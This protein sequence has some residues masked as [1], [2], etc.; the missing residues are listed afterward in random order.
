[1]KVYNN[2][3][4]SEA[5]STVLPTDH[6]GQVSPT[7]ADAVF[8]SGD[9]VVV[10][11]YANTSYDMIYAIGYH[12]PSGVQ[13]Y[14]HVYPNIDANACSVFEDQ[15]I[16]VQKDSNWYT[17]GVVRARASDDYILGSVNFAGTTSPDSKSGCVRFNGSYYISAEY[18]GNANVGVQSGQVTVYDSTGYMVH[19]LINPN[20]AGDADY[21]RFGFDTNFY[22]TTQVVGLT[23]KDTDGTGSNH[24]GHLSLF[25][26]TT[27]L[28]QKT[29]DIPKGDR[30]FE[31]SSFNGPL[32]VDGEWIFAGGWQSNAPTTDYTG[33]LIHCYNPI[34][35][36]SFNLVG[37]TSSEEAKTAHSALGISDADF[38]TIDF[39]RSFDVRDGKLV[40]KTAS[41]AGVIA[42]GGVNGDN[43]SVLYTFTA[44]VAPRNLLSIDETHIATR[45]YAL[46]VSRNAKEDAQTYADQAVVTAVANVVDAAPASLDTLNELAAALGDDENFAVTVTTNLAGKA[47]IASVSTS[48]QEAIDAAALDAT[49]KANAAQAAAIL[50]ASSDA[51]GKAEAARIAAAADATSKANAAQSIAISTASDDATTKANDVQ[52]ICLA[53]ATSKAEAA[54]IAAE[55][56]AAADATAKAAAAQA[57]AA[58]D[59]ATKADAAQAAAIAAA[60][61]DATSKANAALAAAEADATSKAN[62]A[63]AAAEADATAKAEAARI[64]AESAAALDAATKADAAQA[65]AALDATSKADAAQAAA[66]LDA[67]SK[68][69][70]ARIN[71]YDVTGV[72]INN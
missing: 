30:D 14:K 10:L 24:P 27:G 64:A 6:F 52:V 60:E 66:A 38:G 70:G 35:N 32:V 57:A 55:I 11:Q 4:D 37:Y 58:L 23:Y 54:R 43:V 34:S 71:I 63:L 51:T 53:D 65:A 41:D 56:A 62:A 31:A 29:F 42:N 22:G 68:A 25:D 69:N 48:R 20:F 46:E 15:I 72:L 16:Y 8:V 36:S 1:M 19:E 49:S 13:Q 50:Q 21:D 61:A 44:L 12:I 26:L 3:D 7:I 45:A 18:H 47:T 17:T 40:L 9:Y 5:F 33:G 2:S 67:T 39:A 59:A 28:M